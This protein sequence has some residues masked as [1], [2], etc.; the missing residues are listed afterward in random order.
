MTTLE[1][2]KDGARA[3]LGRRPTSQG[4]MALDVA[5]MALDVTRPDGARRREDGARRHKARRHEDGARASATRTAL[6]T[7]SAV[8][9]HEILLRGGW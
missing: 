4:P 8:W 6:S 3:P 7:P 5:R 2:H 1:R 9:F